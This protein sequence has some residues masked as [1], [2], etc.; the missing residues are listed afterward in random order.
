VIYDDPNVNVSFWLIAILKCISCIYFCLHRFR[1]QCRHQMKFTRRCVEW[2]WHLHAT[3]VVN[4]S[5]IY[6]G[7]LFVLFEWF[8]RGWW[9]CMAWL[10][11]WNLLHLLYPVVSLHPHRRRPV[12]LLGAWRRVKTEDSFSCIPPRYVIS[13][14]WEYW[15]VAAVCIGCRPT[16]SH[17]SRGTYMLAYRVRC[18]TMARATQL[19]E[20]SQ[21]AICHIDWWVRLRHSLSRRSSGRRQM[22]C[23]CTGAMATGAIATG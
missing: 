7:D 12:H 13:I 4:I 3:A 2:S 1:N 23:E 22:A 11:Q 15:Q 16:H 20:N 9:D 8:A 6:E 14:G 19:F 5:P 18:D 21:G 10:D 17:T